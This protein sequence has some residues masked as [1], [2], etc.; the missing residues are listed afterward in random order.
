[1]GVKKL[2]NQIVLSGL[3]SVYRPGGYQG[4]AHQDKIILDCALVRD[5]VEHCEAG[6]IFPQG[7]KAK[8]VI[9]GRLMIFFDKNFGGNIVEIDG[10][11]KAGRDNNQQHCG[12]D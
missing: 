12:A 11:D 5:V 8:L 4:I 9:D 2:G 1:M 6:K 10:D 3:Q 7:G